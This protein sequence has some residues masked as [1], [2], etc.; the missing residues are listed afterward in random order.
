MPKGTKKVIASCC[1]VC[2]KA[3]P[4]AE[5]WRGR[6]LV[7]DEKSCRRDVR[8]F[9]KSNATPR[10]IG[11]DELR[12][13][14]P[15]CDNF[16]PEGYYQ[17]NLKYIVC[18]GSC[19][20]RRSW[21]AETLICA[22][23]ACGKEFKARGGYRRYCSKEHFKLHSR[24]VLIDLHCGV[25]RPVFEE[26]ID[27]A[28]LSKRCMSV[29]RSGL[30][31]LL[32]F[33]NEQGIT[34]LNDVVATTI[35]KF[36]KWGEETA[37][38]SVWN[39]IWVV[40]AF[41][42]W[43]IATGRRTKA[44]PVITSYHRRPKAKRLPR[45]YTEEEM[46]YIWSLLDQRGTTV[47]RLAVA[48]AEESGLRIGELCNLRL[49]DID[50]KKQRLF[51]RLPNKT[52]VEAW[53]PFHDKTLMFLKIRLSER[54]SKLSHDFLLCSDRGTPFSTSRLR[55][56]ITRVLCKETHK[57]KYNDEG[58]DSFSTHRLR[59]LMASRLVAGG[60]NAAAIMSIGRWASFSAMQGYSQV[61][62][63][64]KS[65]GY[66]EAMVKARQNRE[67]PTTTTASFRKFVNSPSLLPKAS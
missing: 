12:C 39:A 60:A 30:A 50:V 51:V 9:G 59:H 57:H 67:K 44:N 28:S 37:K 24:D 2:G 61:D 55:D 46:K 62:D 17:P 29:Q 5:M 6:I 45:P 40:S 35:T 53:V 25:F 49:S 10:Y 65:R 52:M 1:S 48:I 32:H 54:D 27:F 11:T 8:A 64:V 15:G 31:L 7:C 3:M 38:P 43:M 47:V 16:V 26:Y 66:T 56:T 23:P 33:V 14:R 42:E 20:W 18:S 41:M 34:D 4:E 21:E 63:A 22:Y 58:L 19:Y 13:G 36:L